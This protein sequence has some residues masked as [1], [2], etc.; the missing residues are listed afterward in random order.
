MDL[1]HSDKSGI[2][3]FQ[4][5]RKTCP[6]VW[7]HWHRKAM[8]WATFF[9]LLHLL[10]AAPCQ[11]TLTLQAGLTWPGQNVILWNISDRIKLKKKTQRAFYIIFPNMLDTAVVKEHHRNNLCET[12]PDRKLQVSEDISSCYFEDRQWGTDVHRMLPGSEIPIRF[13][14]SLLNKFH[15]CFRS[16]IFLNMKYL[17]MKY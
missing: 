2:L 7:I 15:L 8:L 6:C 10:R 12:I 11:Q 1:F 3:I 9:D 4:S 17:N 14:S 16:F 5:C 13:E